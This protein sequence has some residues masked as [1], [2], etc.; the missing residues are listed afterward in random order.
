MADLAADLAGGNIAELCA[1]D[2]TSNS[3]ASCSSSNP[4]L[5]SGPKHT[6]HS[7]FI[8]LV[9]CSDDEITLE[10]ASKAFAS[11]DD[12]RKNVFS[13][14]YKRK[15]FEEVLD[16]V[17]SDPHFGKIFC[18]TDRGYLEAYRSLPNAAKE[19]YCRL[20]LRNDRWLTLAK[21]EQEYRELWEG[22][23]SNFQCS[24]KALCQNG[25]LIS[26][27]GANTSTVEAL[28]PLAR[29]VL[30][31]LA[32]EFKLKAASTKEA[33]ILQLSKHCANQR[34][35]F[36]NLRDAL[37]KK[38]KQKVGDIVRLA[39]NAKMVFVQFFH[40]FS[41]TEMSPL[42]LGPNN[43]QHLAANLVY[44]ML[45]SSLG[46]FKTAI[47]EMDIRK[48]CLFMS[49]SDLE[50][51]CKACEIEVTTRLLWDAKKYEQCV[52][53]V[54]SAKSFLLEEMEAF[55]KRVTEPSYFHDY[56]ACFSLIRAYAFLPQSLEKLKRYKE[57][58]DEFIW[59]I[60]ACDPSIMPRKRGNWYERIVLN[61]EHHL[62]KPLEAL[63]MADMALSEPHLGHIVRSSIAE[64]AKRLQE[65]YCR[66]RKASLNEPVEIVVDDRDTFLLRF[67]IPLKVIQVPV[68]TKSF[69]PSV[70][71]VFVMPG[72]NQFSCTN[73]EAA[74]LK[75]YFDNEN[76]SGGMHTESIIW[77]TLFGLLCWQ[78]VYS[79]DVP[80]VWFSKYQTEPL[81]IYDANLF[82]ARRKD[83]FEK[84]FE[85]LSTLS[86]EDICE[87]IRETW[88]EYKNTVS[89]VSWETFD[90]T[91]P[92]EEVAT[93]IG[94]ALLAKIFYRL[95]SDF[96]RHCSGMPDLLVWNVR[97]RKF[98]VVEVKAVGDRL[99][100]KQKHWLEYLHSIG[101][102]IEVCRVEGT[103]TKTMRSNSQT[104]PTL[105]EDSE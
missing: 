1:L 45:L 74:A 40:F 24:V 32:K 56:S 60:S 55:A 91:T 103:S 14:S 75:Y 96:R 65:S 46:Q 68:L 73:V 50:R 4:G 94:G 105:S 99:S 80:D 52:L 98:K 88:N 70:K 49:R 26:A 18:S 34:T 6:L 97:Q 3:E 63:K 93:V 35:L 101:V 84:K 9:E 69:N 66:K 81:D 39:P 87:R 17:E 38:A 10:C 58:T 95:A 20:F 27:F 33:L 51:Y 100:M 72:K 59:L 5:Q 47:A 79:C 8:D 19:L 31:E 28:K 53:H 42:R 37:M 2:E 78:E 16:V 57:A 7:D 25:F 43:G 92:I 83:H 71:T 11:L 85:L 102:D 23:K 54:Q 86:A 77:L 64:R 41:P 13:K 12:D 62:K 89:L 67:D 30:V 61:Y 36:G 90:T 104:I 44:V 76:Y 29:D 15:F 48:S 82:W 21:L 22:V